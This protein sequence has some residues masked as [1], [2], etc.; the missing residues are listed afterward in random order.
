MHKNIQIKTNPHK[1]HDMFHNLPQNNKKNEAKMHFTDS[2]FI[3]YR[4]FCMA[5]IA[6]SSLISTIQRNEQV[7]GEKQNEILI[8]VYTD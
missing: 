5:S 4:T 8:C 2:F 7:L 6:N 3:A 1:S